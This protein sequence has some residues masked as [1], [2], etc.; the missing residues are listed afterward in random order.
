MLSAT[1]SP[2]DNKLRLYSLSRLDQITYEKVKR[3]GFKWCP[4]Q[5]FFMAPMWTP[6]REDLLL[7]L[8]DEIDDEDRDPTE[9]AE[10]RAERFETYSDNRTR[11]AQ[12]A[13]AAVDAIAQG[14]PLG[15]PILVGH[16]SQRRAE[17]DAEKIENGMRRA[18]KLWDTAEYWKY[19]AKSSRM[20]ARYKELPAVRHRRIKKLEADLRRS[21]KHVKEAN[22]FIHFWSREGLSPE[23]ALQVANHDRVSACFSL[24]K[25]PRSA[26]A[27]QYEG[28]MS[29]WS[30]LKD[31]IITAEQGADL[32]IRAHERTLTWATRWVN[33]FKNRI[34]YETAMLEETGGIAVDPSKVEVG[35]RILVRGEWLVV[36]SINK[37]STGKI[38]SYS[39]LGGSWTRGIEEAKEYRAPGEGDAEK[40]QAIT[41]QP[42]LCNYPGEGFHEMTK[43]EYTQTN[44]DYRCTRIVKSET[45]AAH[46][47]RH[48]MKGNYRM[49]GVYLTDQKRVDPPSAALIETKP[50][51]PREKELP[52]CTMV[53]TPPERTLFDAMRDT[54]KSGGVKAVSTPQ[55][56]ATPKAL[57]DRMV[58]L[59]GIQPGNV[60]LEP[61]AGTGA[62]IRAIKSRHM[63][64]EVIAVEISRELSQALELLPAG[65]H[66]ADFLQC[67]GELP[68]VDRVVMNP[69]FA[70]QG[71]TTDAD[72]IRHAWGYLKPGG[73]LVAL[74]ANGPR[75]QA[76]LKPW[77]E[78]FGTWEALPEGSFKESGTGVNVALMVVDKPC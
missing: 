42:P 17:R 38:A 75:Q 45:V 52:V 44:K 63:E 13:A 55:L 26:E 50:E 62:L 49:A 78:E 37:D 5:G 32:A 22:H 59:A 8:C 70:G 29:L 30:A 34:A 76:N 51:I 24:E 12:S 64:A 4:K 31:G 14:I 43:A 7:S 46:R 48:A 41:K 40:V 57:A 54:L 68:A 3:S 67:N 6:E 65:V 73:R 28:S 1:Y 39:V 36:R 23:Q 20:H 16:H 18:V 35:G 69:P 11:E 53:H 58:E 10:D 25:Y 47:V 21:E 61:S 71:S 33:H 9:T 27:S 15:Q 77:A 19:R 60:V 56:F 2:H 74:C 72:H 66:C